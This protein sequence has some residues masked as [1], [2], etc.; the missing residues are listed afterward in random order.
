MIFLDKVQQDCERKAVNK[1]NFMAAALWVDVVFDDD[2]AF[3]EEM[4]TI[5]LLRIKKMFIPKIGRSILGRFF[6]I[7]INCETG[8]T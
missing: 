4:N 3:G 6:G 2:V 1:N 5:F 7:F 8:Q